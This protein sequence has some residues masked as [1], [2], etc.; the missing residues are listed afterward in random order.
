[1]FVVFLSGYRLGVDEGEAWEG[2]R[3]VRRLVLKPDVT[4]RE[5]TGKFGGV[6]SYF[7]EILKGVVICEG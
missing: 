5:R 6:N 3:E 2:R 4:A 7:E 1:V